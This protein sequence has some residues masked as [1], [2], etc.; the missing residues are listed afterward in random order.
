MKTNID[1]F[2]RQ[3]FPRFILNAIVNRRISVF[4]DFSYFLECCLDCIKIFSVQKT[5]IHIK[6]NIKILIFYVTKILI[7][8]A[9][10][11]TK[12]GLK[13]WNEL[14]QHL[15]FLCKPL[16]NGRNYFFHTIFCL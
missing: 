11:N 16:L 6:M 12:N 2:A 1:F 10:S 7:I 9:T 4:E 13:I 15:S 3:H 5:F 8:R 14:F